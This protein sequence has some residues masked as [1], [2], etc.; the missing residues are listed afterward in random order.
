MNFNA[1]LKHCLKMYVIVFLKLYVF[2]A[3]PLT[4]IL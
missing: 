2:E 3:L 4:K 1:P